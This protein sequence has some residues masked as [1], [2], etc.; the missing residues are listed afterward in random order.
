MVVDRAS[1]VFGAGE[2]PTIPAKTN[3]SESE[4]LS[5]KWIVKSFSYFG[6]GILI[7][8]VAFFNTNVHDNTSVSF[9][10]YIIGRYDRFI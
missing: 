10:K 9:L 5:E 2:T 8:F 6:D 1:P 7:V 3:P 4:V